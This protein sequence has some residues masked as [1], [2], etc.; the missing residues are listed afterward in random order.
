MDCCPAG[1]VTDAGT[2]T[3]GS[4]DLSETTIPPA[5][6]KPLSAARPTTVSPPSADPGP[7]PRDEN[8][9][10][11]IVSVAL[12]VALP[13]PA[14]ITAEVCFV[15][16]NVT[17]ENVAEVAP[18]GTSTNSGTVAF[19]LLEVNFTPNPEA[20]A[21]SASVTIPVDTEPPTNVAGLRDVLAIGSSRLNGFVATA[22]VPE[23]VNNANLLLSGVTANANV[24]LL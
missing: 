12:T 20:G 5:G 15:T 23:Y 14:V 4:L 9:V 7:T 19:G 21:G 13:F 18:G 1:I 8:D 22:R 2:E 10:G 17:T 11:L 24:P 3:D 6:A 16:P